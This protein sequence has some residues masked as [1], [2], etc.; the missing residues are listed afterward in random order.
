MNSKLE[1][2]IK[3]LHKATP[4]IFYIKYGEIKNILWMFSFIINHNLL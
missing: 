4:L 3:L 2:I 1:K